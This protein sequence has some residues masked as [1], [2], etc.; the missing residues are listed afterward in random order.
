MASFDF[1]VDEVG[2]F[3]LLL[4]KG[5]DEG[6]YFRFLF[7]VKGFEDFG[8][9]I[10]DGVFLFLAEGDLDPVIDEDG[11]FFL[12]R[13]EAPGIEGFLDGAEGI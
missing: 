13:P 4:V 11:L 6:F 3:D 8:E 7:E 2:D 10:G 5:L 12:G 1:G 9:V